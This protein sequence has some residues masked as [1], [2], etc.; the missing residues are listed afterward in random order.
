MEMHQ[1]TEPRKPHPRRLLD[2]SREYLSVLELAAL[3]GIGRKLAKKIAGE[4]GVDL[5][6]K[7]TR[8]RR[9]DVD[10]YLDKRR[11]AGWRAR[12]KSR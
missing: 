11:A 9:S 3:L 10:A 1:Q 6:P 7:V 2:P 5:G 4:I 8:V 12:G